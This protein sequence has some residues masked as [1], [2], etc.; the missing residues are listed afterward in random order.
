METAFRICSR[1]VVAIYGRFPVFGELRSSIGLIRRDGEY[2]LQRRADDLGWSFPGG[3]AMFWETEEQTLR[4][5]VREET[6]LPVLRCRPLFVYRSRLYLPSRVTVFEAEVDATR[7]LRG[8]WEGEPRWMGLEPLPQPFFPAQ[9]AV[10]EYLRAQPPPP[11]A[12]G[13]KHPPL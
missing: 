8:S 1:T 4:R 13:R 10:L 7:P 6:G 3:M 5:E 2:L 11:S 9:A 12:E